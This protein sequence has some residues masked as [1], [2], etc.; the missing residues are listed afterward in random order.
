MPGP[1][2]GFALVM[3]RALAILCSVV[4]LAASAASL[5]DSLAP[6]PAWCTAGGC[7]AVRAT[8]W[9]RPLG[10]P[11]PVVGVIFFA[12]MLALSVSDAARVRRALAIVG[13]AGAI[14][15]L[16][17]QAFAIGRWCQLCLVADGAALVLAIAAN[18]AR[19]WP[20]PG[21]RVV[22]VVA[23]VGALA[24][25]APLVAPRDA[26]PAP[27]VATTLPDV[28]A[29]EQVTGQVVVVDFV[30]FECPYC[31]ALHARLVAAIA[32]AGRPVRVVRKMV[33]LGLHAGALPAAIAWC[34]AERQGRG[35][36]MADALLAAPPGQL[37]EEGCA[38]LAAAIGLD[39]AR[40]RA[41]A[42]SPG[43][44]TQIDRDLADA[45]AAGVRSLPTIYIGGVRFVGAAATV[46]ELIGALRR[47]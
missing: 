36:A 6:V 16:G 30:D 47:A 40:Y 27:A 20:P 18:G 8:A 21:R 12:T 37:T 33:P 14:G 2:Q 28:V 10:V 38:R 26:A 19:A 7:A 11:L 41:D 5:A 29:R 22:G 25:V 31:R 23:V 9:A 45:R 15:L 3:T 43:V 44:R 1:S 46:E 4:G 35:D 34:C 42:R 24:V 32:D 17:V 13:G 39:L